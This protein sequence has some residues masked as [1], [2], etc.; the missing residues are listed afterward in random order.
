MYDNIEYPQSLIIYIKTN[1]PNF[2]YITF[3]PKMIEPQENS[4]DVYFTSQVQLT[5]KCIKNNKKETDKNKDFSE[6]WNVFYNKYKFNN[7]VV[8]C[9]NQQKLTIGDLKKP[10]KYYTDAGNISHNIQMTLDRIF[11]TNN[12]LHLGSKPY[13]IYSN[14]FNSE[15]WQMDTKPLHMIPRDLIQQADK[16][17]SVIKAT[18]EDCVFGKSATNIVFPSKKTPE[19]NAVKNSPSLQ[20]LT[21]SKELAVCDIRVFFYLV[22]LKFTFDER[23]IDEYIH[24]LFDLQSEIR[25]IALPINHT[26]NSYQNILLQKYKNVFA[27]ILIFLKTFR[28][29]YVENTK[30][31]NMDTNSTTTN[32]INYCANDI[33]IYEYFMTINMDVLFEVLNNFP[34]VISSFNADDNT[35]DIDIHTYV[36]NILA[37]QSF[38]IFYKYQQTNAWLINMQEKRKQ[39]KQKEQEQDYYLLFGYCTLLDNVYFFQHKFIDIYLNPLTNEFQ[40]NVLICNKETQN[41]AMCLKNLKEDNKKITAL[42]FHLFI[43]YSQKNYLIKFCEKKHKINTF[44]KKCNLLLNLLK[45]KPNKNI[46]GTKIQLSETFT[47]LTFINLEQSNLLTD[48][49]YIFAFS[50]NNNDLEYNIQYLMKMYTRLHNKMCSKPTKEKW[51]L[52]RPV[53]PALNQTAYFSQL[54]T[55]NNINILILNGNNLHEYIFKPEDSIVNADLGY[56]VLIQNVNSYNQITYSFGIRPNHIMH[57]IKPEINGIKPEING[58]AMRKKHRANPYINY[59]TNGIRDKAFVQ[60]KSKIYKPNLLAYYIEI[61]LELFPAELNGKFDKK[62]SFICNKRRIEIKNIVEYIKNKF[63]SISVASFK[64]KNVPT[65]NTFAIPPIVSAL[66]NEPLKPDIGAKTHTT[67]ELRATDQLVQEKLTNIRRAMKNM[68]MK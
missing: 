58:G 50:P 2:E 11:K 57:E 1:I 23:L 27:V 51:E 55:L 59:N 5:D 25:Q 14:S 38:F 24:A 20:K 21:I 34:T 56:F 42:F 52:K 7:M 35:T 48:K 10:L 6:K 61:S 22:D 46:T 13:S 33:A 32:I 41:K 47:N 36:Q 15:S 31:K 43:Q 45:P 54:M 18:C 62:Q 29:N 4:D 64:T 37:I 30:N 19:S 40:K 39:S 67:V 28:T 16:D 66:P 65:N 63:Y 12:I 9:A 60:N 53:Q 68:Y 44:D 8:Q 17:L 49:I 26:N 3:M